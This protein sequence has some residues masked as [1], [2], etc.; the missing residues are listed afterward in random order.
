MKLKFFLRLLGPIIFIILFYVY[1][2][3]YKLIDILRASKWQF[4]VVGLALSPPLIYI[5]SIRWRIILSAYDIFY[6]KWQC[7]KIYFVEML[8]IMMVAAVGTFA[9]AVY[10]KRDGHGLLQPLLSIMAEK[11]YDYLLPLIFGA[12]SLF[13]VWI[14]SDSA[15]GLVLFSLLSLLAFIPAHKACLLLSPRLLPRRLNELLQKKGWHINEHLVKIHE[16]LNFKMYIYSISAFGLYFVSIYCL[17]KGLRLELGFFQVVLIM[18]ITSL[19]TLIPISV[20][21]IGTRDAGLLAVFKFFGH[22]AEQA[23]ALSMV[24]LLLRIAIVF[25]GSIFWFMDP[26]PLSELKQ[27]K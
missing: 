27:L 11:Y 8:A 15:S 19:I 2:D 7:F 9:K 17:T 1:V 6:T 14:G 5:R 10:L 25:I 20:L 3:F 23:V 18:T 26:P 16:I 21:G 12:I 22:T 4:F 24:L 13:L